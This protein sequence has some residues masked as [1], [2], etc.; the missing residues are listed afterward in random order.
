MKTLVE[1]PPET[2][3]IVD[4]EAIVR[5]ITNKLLRRFGYQVLMASD[6]NEAIRI[7]ESK[8]QDIDVILLDLNMPSLNGRSTVENIRKINPF[9]NIIVSSGFLQEQQVKHLQARGIEYFLEKPFHPDDLLK[10]I[11]SSVHNRN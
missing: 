4:D 10:I 8:H 2:V 1:T 7:Y 6:G 9:A 5:N 11:R 3:L